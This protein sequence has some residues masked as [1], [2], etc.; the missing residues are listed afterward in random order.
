MWRKR[1]LREEYYSEEGE[2]RGE[3]LGR[4]GFFVLLLRN[5]EVYAVPYELG[6]KVLYLIDPAYVVRLT[7]PVGPVESE[8]GSLLVDMIR[9][10][11]GERNV[12]M[13]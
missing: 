6:G 7:Q 5:G 2:I 4:V 1:L 9:A 11:V 3:P 8:N 10:A 13:G 12:G